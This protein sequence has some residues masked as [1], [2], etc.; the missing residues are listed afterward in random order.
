MK[1]IQNKN[2]YDENI[3]LVFYSKSKDGPYPGDGAG[4]KMEVDARTKFD[5]YEL[6]KIP[7]WRKMLSNFWEQEFNL[8]GLRWLSVEHYYQASKFKKGFPDFF[9]QF[10]ID[11]G[12]DISKDTVLAKVA[13]GKT[14]RKGSTVLREKHIV[15]DDD[16][17]TTNRC[18]EDMS[19]AQ[20][21]KFSQNEDL[22]KCLLATKNAKL[23]H[24]V[25]GSDPVFF[26]SLVVI[27]SLLKT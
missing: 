1:L 14:G 8:D 22:K 21:A 10:S 26:L 16:F 27:R 6:S 7:N 20:H 18:R 23:V 3:V 19:R 17:F 5:Y 15:V 4:E 25:R 24:Y 12:S 11:S 2:M 13:G 9:Y